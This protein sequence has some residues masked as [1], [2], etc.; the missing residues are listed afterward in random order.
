MRGGQTGYDQHISYS[1]PCPV[2]AQPR[3]T[4]KM[5][6]GKIEREE[7]VSGEELARSRGQK[8][9]KESLWKERREEDGGRLE[10]WHE[11]A[12][13]ARLVSSPPPPCSPSTHPLSLAS[14]N[15]DLDGAHEVEDEKKAGESC[16]RTGE[17]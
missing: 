15:D 13:E 10:V 5:R 1:P 4:A 3:S 16:P 12:E 17:I 8:I 14:S 2:L 9:T 7:G 6:R 11:E